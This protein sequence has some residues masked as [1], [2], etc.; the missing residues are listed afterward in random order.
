M[1]AFYFRKDRFLLE[2]MQPYNSPE[3]H[4]VHTDHPSLFFLVLPGMKREG[5]KSSWKASLSKL[6]TH[7]IDQ[8]SGCRQPLQSTR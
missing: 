4:Q 2:G 3:F 6:N 8:M 5:N 1:K 7:T